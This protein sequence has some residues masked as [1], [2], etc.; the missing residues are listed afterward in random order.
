MSSQCKTDAKS[1]TNRFAVLQKHVYCSTRRVDRSTL[2]RRNESK[3]QSIPPPPTVYGRLGPTRSRLGLR[4]RLPHGLLKTFY[5]IRKRKNV[6]RITTNTTLFYFSLIARS[7]VPSNEESDPKTP[8][9]C[10]SS[11]APE[12]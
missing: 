5:G 10:P 4:E 3:S 8:R 6:I 11:G 7:R 9:T 2:F 12:N 1:S